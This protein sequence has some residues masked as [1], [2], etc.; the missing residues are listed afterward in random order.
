V[1][2]QDILK[3]FNIVKNCQISYYEI[4]KYFNYLIRVIGGGFKVRRTPA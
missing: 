2:A 3:V 1:E 4:V